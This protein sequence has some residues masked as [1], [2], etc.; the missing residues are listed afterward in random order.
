MTAKHTPGPWTADD[1][2]DIYAKR[3]GADEQ[4]A[5]AFALYDPAYPEHAEWGDEA[6]ANARLIA[7]AP[8][9]LDALAHL[10]AEI[11]SLG[12]LDVKKRF[13]LMVYHAA[14]EKAIRKATGGEPCADTE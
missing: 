12:L 1:N 6:K 3:N 9:L 2:G 13:W 7:A 11:R 10:T 8:D 5:E 14:A 4:I